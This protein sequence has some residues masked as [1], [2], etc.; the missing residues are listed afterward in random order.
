MDTC[1]EKNDQIAWF[2]GAEMSNTNRRIRYLLPVFLFLLGAWFTWDMITE[3]TD[4]VTPIA[5]VDIMN[6]HQIRKVVGH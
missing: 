1:I 4:A 2:R 6:V 3:V 5:V